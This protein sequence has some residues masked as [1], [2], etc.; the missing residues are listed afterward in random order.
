MASDK[1]ISRLKQ[2]AARDKDKIEQ[3]H[4]NGAATATRPV[5]HYRAYLF[6]I[7]LLAALVAFG[8]LFFFVRTTAYFSFD[9]S[10]ERA[11][12]SVRG[13][14][15]EQLMYFVS[16]LGFFPLSVILTGAIILFIFVIGL[17]WEAVM[18][19]FA[20]GGVTLAG[21]VI[22]EIVQ[23]A[24]PTPDLVNVLSPLTDYSFPSGHVLHFTAFLGFLIFMFFT[25]TPRSWVRTAGILVCAL[26][27]VLVGISR[28]Y[29]GQH[30]PSDVMGAYLFA[31]IWLALTIY[32]YRW[33]KSR[34]F[35]TQ[36][37]AP[38]HSHNSEQTKHK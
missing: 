10:V 19:V 18:A 16:G 20:A 15:W 23:R 37:A 33:G 12:Q 4:P 21:I 3:S 8:V 14:G 22:K 34:F 1:P 25:I 31:S 26:L 5:R 30:W 38:E 35:V 7:Y 27:I 2:Q 6:Q 29:L 32:I 28:M 36:P 9:L 11:V 13:F 17:R 24:R